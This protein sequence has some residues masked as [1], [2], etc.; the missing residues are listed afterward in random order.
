MQIDERK[1]KVKQSRKEEATERKARPIMLEM[2]NKFSKEQKVTSYDKLSTKVTR[3]YTVSERDKM[4]Q[5]RL[6][7]VRHS[8][9]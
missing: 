1:E 5:N 2:R 4:E 3:S 7:V 6:G 8:A 9:T